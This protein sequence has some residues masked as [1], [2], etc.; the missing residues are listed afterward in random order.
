MLEFKDSKKVGGT[1]NEISP[2]VITTKT[3][4]LNVSRILI[5]N[6]ILC[7]NMYPELFEKMGLEGVYG[8]T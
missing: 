2:L 6:G 5:D 1:P 7:S 8:R 4:H 3:R